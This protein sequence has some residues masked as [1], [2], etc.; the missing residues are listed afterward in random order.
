[1]L[2]QGARIILMVLLLQSEVAQ[3]CYRICCCTLVWLVLSWLIG[4]L[5]RSHGTVGP[6]LHLHLFDICCILCR[7][8]MQALV[9][10]AY[11]RALVDLTTVRFVKRIDVRTSV[12]AIRRGAPTFLTCHLRSVLEEPS[13]GWDR[14][15]SSE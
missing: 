5:G 9:W 3:L 14:L 8:Q 11:L 6:L 4:G 13:R 2:G 7:V 1:M 15:A 10:V 12:A